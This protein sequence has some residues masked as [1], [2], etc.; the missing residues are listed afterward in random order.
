M[1]WRLFHRYW[2]PRGI[3][4][5]ILINLRNIARI[6]FGIK[7]QCFKRPPVLIWRSHFLGTNELTFGWNQFILSKSIT[8]KAG[9]TSLREYIKLRISCN[10]LRPSYLYNGMSYTGKMTSSYWT[11]AKE[12]SCSRWLHV[13][14][15]FALPWWRPHLLSLE[16]TRQYEIS[17][18]IFNYVSGFH[19]VLQPVNLWWEHV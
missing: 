13:T 2:N 18:A 15:T 12:S 17:S 8:N 11:K 14:R 19:Q 6:I 5:Q 16:R 1:H 10:G 3:S 7:Y 9:K 4:F